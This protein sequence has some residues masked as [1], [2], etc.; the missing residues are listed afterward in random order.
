MH[1]PPGVAN[2]A[3]DLVRFAR[4]L[5]EHVIFGF[6]EAYAEYLDEPPD[7]LPLIHEGRKVICMRTFSKVHGLA[8]LR[9]GYGYGSSE[10]VTLLHRVRQPFNANAIAQAAACAALEDTE[11]V[12]RCRQANQEGM[13]QWETGCKELGLSH[14]PSQANFILVKVGTATKVFEALL[15]RGII[16]RSQ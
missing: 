1:N 14:I 2:S 7:L 8:G 5:P 13:R 3:E 11:H 6:D 4:K 9:I 16:A 15:D 10:L 12:A